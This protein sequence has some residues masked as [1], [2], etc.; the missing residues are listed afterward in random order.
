MAS[1]LRYVRACA[2]VTGST[3]ALMF[4]TA[5]HATADAATGL[6][7]RGGDVAGYAVNV[8]EGVFSNLATSLIGFK[9]SD[10]TVLGT[11]CVEINTEIDDAQEMVE[12]PWED[13]PDLDSPFAQNRDKLN[14]VLH[15]G[16]PVREPASLTQLLTQVGV[17]TNGGIDEREAIAGTQA[18]VWHF[19]D[20]TDLNREDPLPGDDS[21]AAAAEDV[22]AL[23]DFLTGDANVGMAEEPAAA[24]AIDPDDLAGGAGERIGPFTVSTTAEVAQ[25]KA[26]LPE[27]VRV[28]DAE[29]N[30]LNGGQVRD[31]AEVFV[32][33]PEGTEAGQATFEVTATAVVDTGRLFVGQ[34]YTEDPTQS[35]IVAKA[36]ESTVTAQ[37][38]AS[39]T[40]GAQ[41]VQV[42]ND[43]EDVSDLAETGASIFAPVLFGIGLVVAGIVAVMFVRARRRY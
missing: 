31:G 4:A 32:D 20:D 16:F 5:G 40:D 17:S 9:L 29:G 38:T 11:Y 42:A 13:Y 8:G 1:V 39:W 2:A 21:N 10:G 43:D 14:W 33:V 25:L 3:A 19:S 23:Y 15:T 18:A 7:D 12:R 22:L 28:I 26:T 30:D 36:V 27:G 41:V 6:V 34:N 24:L 35:L 37:A